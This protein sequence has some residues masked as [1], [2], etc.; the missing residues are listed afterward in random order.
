MRSTMSRRLRRLRYLIEAH[1][2]TIVTALA[3]AFVVFLLSGGLFSIVEERSVWMIPVGTARGVTYRFY[4]PGTILMQTRSECIVT[5]I[6]YAGAFAGLYLVYSGLR[7]VYE[8]SHAMMLMTLGSMMTLIA[9]VI[10]WVLLKS[11]VGL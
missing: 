4:W 10:L 3:L 5:M 6:A 2:R 8:P 1:G 11:K 7:R 9:L